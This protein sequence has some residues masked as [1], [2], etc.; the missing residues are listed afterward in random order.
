MGWASG[1]NSYLTVALLSLLGRSGWADVPEELQSDGVLVTALVLYAIEFVTDKV[2]YLDS[3]WDVIHTAVRPA[4]GS[5]VGVALGSDAGVSGMEQALAGGGSGAMA[6]AS[7]A[8]KASVRLGVNASPEP[9]SNII[10]SLTEDVLVAGVA[11]LALQHPV[12]AALIA[13]TLLAAGTALAV[14]L[15]RRIRRAARAL[16][17]RLRGPPRSQS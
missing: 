5:L 1:V 14:F 15:A 10:V 9:A 3:T 7:H 12:P 13:V 8:V 11:A 16:R 4:I 17:A 6:L 2:P